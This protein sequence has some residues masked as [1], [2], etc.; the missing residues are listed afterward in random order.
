MP[1]RPL[2]HY[3]PALYHTVFAFLLLPTRV[4]LWSAMVH[5]H[6][7]IVTLRDIIAPTRHDFTDLQIVFDFYSMDIATLF[8]TVSQQPEWGSTHIKYL[9]FQLL[10]GV[11][12]LH[13]ASIIHRDLKPSNLL[14]NEACELKICDFGLARVVAP[15]LAGD[16][17]GGASEQA[18]VPLKRALTTH[19]VT[20]WY[21][22]PELI[23]Q[24]T[25]YNT[26]IDIWCVT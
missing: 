21:R 9:L 16:G 7:C 25:S 12:Y 14:A 20:R 6:Q 5:S 26:S 13:S 3:A 15:E 8:A 19:V 11:N 23:M 22:A 18:R 2:A 24:D 17:A 10:S 4:V 1:V